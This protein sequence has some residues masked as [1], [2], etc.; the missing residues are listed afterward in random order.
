MGYGLHDPRL[1][2]TW[3]QL[4]ADGHSVAHIRAQLDAGRWRRWGYAIALHNGPLTEEQTWFVARAQAGPQALLTGF[5][6]TQA[7]GLVGWSRDVVHVLV[8]PGARRVVACP[9]P[10]RITHRSP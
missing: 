4:L 5:T 6:A 1:I 8:P 3:S 7:F 10:L 2:T 9:V